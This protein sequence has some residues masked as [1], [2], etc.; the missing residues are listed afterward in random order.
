MACWVACPLVDRG[1]WRG[2]DGADVDALAAVPGH[3]LVVVGVVARVGHLAEGE[4]LVEAGVAGPLDGWRT[5]GGGYAADVQ[6][7]TALLV[8]DGVRVRHAGH[9]AEVPQLLVAALA[10]VLLLHVPL[11]VLRLVLSRHCCEC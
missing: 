10:V 5:I 6:A 3:E 9:R 2:G 8:D 1:T 7:F 4:L 11:A